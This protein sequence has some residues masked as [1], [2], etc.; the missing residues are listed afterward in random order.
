M[1]DK[2]TLK[3]DTR[4]VSGKKV[5]QLR[6]DSIVP[7]VIYGPGMEP[8]SVQ[9][10]QNDITKV[11]KE[12]GKHAPVHVDVA[13]KKRIAMIK[14]IDVDHIKNT[15]RHI[16]FHAVNA[17]DPVTAEVPIRL[18]GEGES[19][20]EKAGLIIL[21]NLETVEVK[22]LPMDLPDAIE[23]SIV[24]LKE[25]GEKVTLGDAKL[26]KGVEFVEHTDGHAHD[27]EEDEDQPTI[28]DLMVASV[29]EPSALQAQNESAGGDAEDESEVEADNGAD[30]PQDTQ[31]EETRPGGK[32][33]DEPKQSNVDANK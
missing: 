14:D 15:V 30:T 23:V 8:V 21:Q 13:G 6:R 22:A 5:A 28:Y 17:S 26:M 2:I 10:H 31:A 19:E 18:I 27:E 4:D 3:L 16:S 20:A 29:W 33:Q 12:A 1:G 32:G 11:Y 9:A 25:P 24:H 7:G